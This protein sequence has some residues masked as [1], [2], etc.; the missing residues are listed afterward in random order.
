METDEGKPNQVPVEKSVED[1][2]ERRKVTLRLRE[3][4]I[5]E[6]LEALGDGGHCQ[7]GQGRLVRWDQDGMLYLDFCFNVGSHRGDGGLGIKAMEVHIQIPLTDQEL[8][9]IPKKEEE[10]DETPVAA[11]PAAA[12]VAA[13]PPDPVVPVGAPDPGPALPAVA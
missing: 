7:T 10:K 13:A 6:I 9:L 5:R 4:G 3:T 2:T 8:K 12:P 1:G 11:P